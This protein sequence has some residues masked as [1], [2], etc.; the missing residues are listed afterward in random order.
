M[1]KASKK[2][3]GFLNF[4]APC[5]TR[6][7][8]LLITNHIVDNWFKTICRNILTEEYEQWE[9]NQPEAQRPRVLDKRDLGGG[10]SEVS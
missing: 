5:P 6:T 3:R 9:A 1:K 8:H 7:D 2:L 10:K 4:G